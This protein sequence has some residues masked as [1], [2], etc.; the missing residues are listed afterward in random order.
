M[1]KLSGVMEIFWNLTWLFETVRILELEGVNLC[2]WLYVKDIS[3]KRTV[4]R[5]EIY[6]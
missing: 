4:Q 3:I 5:R 6:I 2:I 1:R